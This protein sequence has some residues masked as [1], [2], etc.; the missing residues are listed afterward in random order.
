MY[1]NNIGD[2][3]NMA[4][5]GNLK[6]QYPG[7]AA[8]WIS[9]Y[10][11]EIEVSSIKRMFELDRHMFAYQV[12]ASGAIPHLPFA[13][14]SLSYTKIEPYTYTHTRNLNP[15]NGDTPMVTSYINNGMPLGYYIPPNSDE[16]KLR[17][18]MLPAPRTQTHFQYQMVRH[19]ADY[20]SFSVD[21][22]SL[23]SE[24]SAPNRSSEPLLRKYFLK[25]GAYQWMHIV[26]VGGEHTFEKLKLPFTVF[27]EVGLVFSYFT[28]IGETFDG[29]PQGY[30]VI[31]TQEYPK[32]TAFIVNLGI[33][34][35][36]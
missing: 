9:G 28:N 4:I 22:S 17:F 30:S 20:G 33:R 31:D 36:L 7:I 3:D 16:I 25:D 21:G 35:F 24:L 6:V 5:F 12:G 15:W 13:S 26:K 34:M 1:Q 18:E 8:L 27:G 32:S 23:L 19:G 14:A 11:D 2:Y 29:S 10:I